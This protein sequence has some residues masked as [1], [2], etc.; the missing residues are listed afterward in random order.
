[1]NNLIFS[2]SNVFKISDFSIQ[3]NDSSLMLPNV[4]RILKPSQKASFEKLISII[5]NNLEKETQLTLNTFN[6]CYMEDHLMSDVGK[7]IPF[8]FSD[9][10]AEDLLLASFKAKN[11]ETRFFK[12]FVDYGTILIAEVYKQTM[13][14]I[15]FGH[16]KYEFYQ[17]DFFP[18]P[19]LTFEFLEHYFNVDN[20]DN[21]FDVF[22]N[23]HKSLL[24]SWTK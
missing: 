9:I 2:A 23:A 13:E 6:H 15:G 1:M 16:I 8:S 14:R 3:R 22:D 10:Y 20:E 19:C 21:L 7:T 17:D 4:E 5:I 12:L 18:N 24:K 11:E